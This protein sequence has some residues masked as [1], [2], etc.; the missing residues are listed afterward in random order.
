MIDWSGPVSEFASCVVPETVRDVVVAVLKNAV[1]DTEI[2]VDDAYGNCDAAAVDDAKNTPC[3]RMDDVV[4]D[5]V[6]LNELSDEKRYAKA[7]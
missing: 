5:V 4:A 2:A 7:E 1:P 3:V 6:V